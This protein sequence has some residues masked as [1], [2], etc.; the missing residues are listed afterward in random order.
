M[1]LMGNRPKTCLA[2]FLGFLLAMTT[3]VGADPRFLS[4]SEKSESRCGWFSNPT[5]G[6][7]SLHDRER[8]WIIGVQGGHQAKGDWPVLGPKQWVETNVHY[9]YGCACLRVRVNRSTAE[10][11]EIESAKARPLST[12]R[13]DQKLKRWDFK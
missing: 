8:E 1:S 9:G 12:C 4:R 11:I 2:F 10:V 7:A 5:P 13:N 3:L 6:N